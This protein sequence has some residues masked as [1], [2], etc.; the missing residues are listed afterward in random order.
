MRGSAHPAP[1][2]PRGT[3]STSTP[4]PPAPIVDRP[5]EPQRDRA[6]R[7]TAIGIVG[8]VI[9]GFVVLIALL[10]LAG[11]LVLGVR[12]ESGTSTTAQVV[13]VGGDEIVP[14][15]EQFAAAW[16]LGD[17]AALDRL[18]DPG[19]VEVVDSWPSAELEVLV[20]GD[21]ELHVIDHEAGYLLLFRYELDPTGSRVVDL[22]HTGFGADGGDG[23]AAGDA[24]SDA[25]ILVEAPAS[26]DVFV[27]GD[28]VRG[29]A[30]TDAVA[31]RLLAGDTEL[32]GGSVPVGEDGTFEFRVGFTN[33]CC[34]EMV[35][36]ITEVDGVGAVDV[37]LTFPEP[38]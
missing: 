7:W 17:T 2:S 35:L 9:G 18:S 30:S 11:A 21:D 37:P 15:I 23:V 20:V 31:Y 1:P 19:V 22:V 33:T 8:L 34:T 5:H 4:T 13:P 12:S 6:R 29:R 16:E 26:G 25:P 32:T 27:D 28:L 38:G 36:E 24:P 3:V 10:L 14:P